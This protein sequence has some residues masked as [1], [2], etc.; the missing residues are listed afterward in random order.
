MIILNAPINQLGYGIASLNI[1]RE[2]SKL[3]DVCLIPIGQPDVTNQED[4]N[5]C[6]QALDNRKHHLI[7]LPCV[8]IWHQHDMKRLTG[9][10]GKMI[11]FPIFELD[12]FT[13]QEKQ[14]LN[15]VDSLIVCSKWAQSVIKNNNIHVPT[16][17]VPLGVDTELFRP[18]SLDSIRPAKPKDKTIFFNCGKWEIRKGHDVLIKVWDKFSQ[19]HDNVELWMM[20]D[21]PFNT[22]QEKSYWESLYNRPN[23][24]LI[25]R[26]ET[27]EE[28]YNI[29]SKTD[30]G[31]FPSRAEGWNLELLE[32]MACGK[33]VITTNYSA[34]TEFCNSDNSY[35]V[36]IDGL[37][38]AF[39]TKWF[40]GHGNWAEITDFQEEC[41]VNHMEQ[42][43]L[44]KSNALSTDGVE[45]AKKLTW[46]NTAKEILDYV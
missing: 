29:M 1:L 39:D 18:W 14:E 4:A 9:H 36:E 15:S 20:C 8:K 22:P 3:T 24:K 23:I 16:T 33:R 10:K 44:D 43:I 6:Q 17:V 12:T 25:P 40:H 19:K 41:L 5:L 11:G 42:V 45:T 31:I 2:L 38:P 28:V 34:H 46:A 35:L 26:V 30:C 32:M 37:E 21:N 7:D 27:Q 13:D